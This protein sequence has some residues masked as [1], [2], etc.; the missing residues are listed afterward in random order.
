MVTISWI[1]R[2]PTKQVFVLRSAKLYQQKRSPSQDWRFHLSFLWNPARF[3]LSLYPQWVVQPLPSSCDLLVC[4]YILWISNHVWN[5]TNGVHA[6]F[7]FPWLSD[8]SANSRIFPSKLAGSTP[9]LLSIRVTDGILAN[10]VSRCW[11]TLIMI[12]L[13]WSISFSYDR[14]MTHS[15]IPR[16]MINLSNQESTMRTWTCCITLSTS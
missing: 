8:I 6:Y 9:E 11:N 3:S 2:P 7:T 16:C 4:Y 5:E 12:M 15:R 14:Y 1:V 10:F 13:Q